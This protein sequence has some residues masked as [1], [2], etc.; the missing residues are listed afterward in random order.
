MI[1]KL[2]KT[3]I[4]TRIASAVVVVLAIILFNQSSEIKGLT[5][6]VTSADATI[7]NHEDAID[8][9]MTKVTGLEKDLDTVNSVLAGS[10]ATRG[11]LAITV[12][13]LNSQLETTTLNLE[14][15]TV[16]LNEALANPVCP[17]ATQ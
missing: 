15:N 16:A 3:T 5:A 17:T 2:K 13:D 6:E 14:A 7:I 8:S 4:G 1:E 12:A 11:E 9:L 10:E